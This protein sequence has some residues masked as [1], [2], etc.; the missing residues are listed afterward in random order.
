MFGIDLDDQMLP[1]SLGNAI[2]DSDL[3][4]GFTLVFIGN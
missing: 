2:L 3:V 4:N 1:V